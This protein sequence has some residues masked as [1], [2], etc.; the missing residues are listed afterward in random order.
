[1][2]K[3]VLLFAVAVFVVWTSV[4][5]AAVGGHGGDLVTVEPITPEAP[6][7]AVRD[8]IGTVPIT[9]SPSAPTYTEAQRGQVAVEFGETSSVAVFP[10]ITAQVSSGGTAAIAFKVEAATLLNAFKA[11]AGTVFAA[12]DIAL[13]LWHAN[14]TTFTKY[15]YA[16]TY[17]TQDLSAAVA[18]KADEKT[19]TFVDENGEPVTNLESGKAVYPKFNV[20][21]NNDEDVNKTAGVIEIQPAAV[22]ASE[23]AGTQGG[24]G[25]GGCDA[26]FSSGALLLLAG[27]W[28]LF[29]KRG[30]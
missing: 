17:I 24:G 8:I 22:A 15:T 11:P 7:D 4:A 1:M 30:V 16:P 14:G 13:I 20:T 27:G 25:G 26:G 6:S 3:V 9:V 19:F 2:K 10:N 12:Q 28:F 21:D 5:Y 29:K 23:P 18:S